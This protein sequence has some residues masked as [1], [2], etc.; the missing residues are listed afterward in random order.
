LPHLELH[1]EIIHSDAKKEAKPNFGQTCKHGSRSLAAWTPKCHFSPVSSSV[2][3]FTPD[4]VLFISSEGGALFRRGGSSA[5]SRFLSRAYAIRRGMGRDESS[6][7]FEEEGGM[8][9]MDQFAIDDDDVMMQD[10]EAMA[11]LALEVAGIRGPRALAALGGRPRQRDAPQLNRAAA[12]RNLPRAEDLHRMA[13]ENASSYQNPR[14]ADL[15]QLG[16]RVR[17][18][19]GFELGPGD[20]ANVALPPVGSGEG[21]TVRALNPIPRRP[22]T[23][24]AEGEADSNIAAQKVFGFKLAFSGPRPQVGAS[25]GGCYLVGVA[26]ASFTAFGDRNALQQ[27]PF[28]WGIEDGGSKF[29]G[30]S[31]RQRGRSSTTYGIEMGR[32]EV[33]FNDN[34]MLFGSHEELTVVVDTEHRT[35]TYWRNSRLLGT[36][37]T[38]LPRTGSLYP[39]AVPF[40]SGASVAISD[41]NGNPVQS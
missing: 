24:N 40:N 31:S 41:M 33:P 19:S 2:S 15:S 4:L 17:R 29:E 35:L 1:F 26:S 34:D 11:A 37:V 36:L 14:W 25:M 38:N 27:S 3:N 7:P 20:L 13:R 30:P 8:S 9:I 18:E 6:N 16:G 39:V 22:V 10:E 32:S 12:L 23:L 28:F 21:R 5:A